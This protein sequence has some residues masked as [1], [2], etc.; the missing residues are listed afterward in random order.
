MRTPSLLL[1]LVLL[2]TA[3]PEQKEEAPPPTAPAPEEAAPA[4]TKPEAPPAVELTGCYQWSEEGQ[5]PHQL[6]ITGSEGVLSAE[7]LGVEGPDFVA[8]FKTDA[9]AVKV[10]GV[11]LSFQLGERDLWGDAIGL[12][13]DLSGKESDGFSR[14]L[15]TYSGTLDAKGFTFTCEA[16]GADEHCTLEQGVFARV[17]AKVCGPVPTGF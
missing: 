9:K 15:W 14:N 4:P 16:E 17:D 11:K 8:W 3:C 6:R 2:L 10:E 7:Y 12:D 1:A 5:E 13:T